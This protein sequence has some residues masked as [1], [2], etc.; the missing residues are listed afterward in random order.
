MIAIPSLKDILAC[1]AAGYDAPE[2]RYRAHMGR[3]WLDTLML[4]RD[5]RADSETYIAAHAAWDELLRVTIR[6]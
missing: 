3:M 1:V 5:V 6:G 4:R 2:R